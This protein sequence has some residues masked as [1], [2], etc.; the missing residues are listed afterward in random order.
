MCFCTPS[1]SFAPQPARAVRGDATQANLFN[2]FNEGKKALV[3]SI[4]GEFD[5]V[6]IGARLDS[7]VND[8]EVLMLSFLT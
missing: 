8:N 4:A 6:A 1:Q 2:L 7:L 3:R 5:E